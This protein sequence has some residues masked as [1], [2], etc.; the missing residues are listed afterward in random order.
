MYSEHLKYAVKLS[1]E[2]RAGLEK[3]V[4]RGTASEEIRKRASILLASD[5]RK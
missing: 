3:I 5:I 2:E 1:V 4:E